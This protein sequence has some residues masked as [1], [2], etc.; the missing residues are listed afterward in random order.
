M[1]NILAAVFTWIL[2]AGYIVLPGT[3]TSFKNSETYKNTEGDK[4]KEVQNQILHGIANLPLAAIAGIFCSI[5]ALGMMWLWFLW[6]DNY[7]WL[8]NKIFM[9]GCLNSVAGLLTAIVN[10]Y[11]VSLPEP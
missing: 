4:S 1:H 6:R 11:T 10:V 3:F 2:L 9:P 5:G 8:I 7:I